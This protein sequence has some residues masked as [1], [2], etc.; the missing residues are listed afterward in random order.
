MGVKRK[1]RASGTSRGR[2]GRGRLAASILGP[3]TP[4][5]TGSGDTLIAIGESADETT[6]CW[7]SHA[8]LERDKLGARFSIVVTEE[9]ALPTGGQRSLVAAETAHHVERLGG[10]GEQVARDLEELTGTE[11]RHVVLGHL[12]RG[13][14]PS[15]YDRMLATRFGS[16]AVELIQRREFGVMTALRSPDIV[17]VSLECIVGQTRKVPVNGDVVRTARNVGISF[18]D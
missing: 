13:G 10:V 2:G 7:S 18:G 9:G 3:G 5:E 11:A 1:F 15:S 17:A 14:S 8:A 12:Q 6:G 4:L 16:F